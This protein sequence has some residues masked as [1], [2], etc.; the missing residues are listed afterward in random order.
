ML[1]S[2]APTLVVLVLSL[3]CSNPDE[4]LGDWW[5]QVGGYH[6]NGF[7]SVLA[8]LLVFLVIILSV[9]G[10]VLWKEWMASGREWLKNSV[11]K[12]DVGRMKR[13]AVVTGSLILYTL[14][15][16]LYFNASPGRLVIFEYCFG[17]VA[18]ATGNERAAYFYFIQADINQLQKMFSYFVA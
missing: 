17:T 11:L 2:I 3:G 7:V 16:V 12:E 5:L 10:L 4:K 6:F 13:V 14:F 8:I 15:S 9:T 1:S 18:A